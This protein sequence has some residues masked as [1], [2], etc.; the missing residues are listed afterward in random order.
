M[1]ISLLPKKRTKESSL[2]RKVCEGITA[3]L[4]HVASKLAS[5][6]QSRQS[7]YADFAG[8]PSRKPFQVGGKYH[9][10]LGVTP[11]YG[12]LCEGPVGEAD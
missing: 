2:Q 11:I 10:A 7:H 9:D 8:F 1:F 5:L 3:Y 12:S 6:K 4:L